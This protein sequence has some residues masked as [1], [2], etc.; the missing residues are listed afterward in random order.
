VIGSTSFLSIPIYTR[1]VS[2]APRTFLTD[3]YQFSCSPVEENYDS[4]LF[5]HLGSHTC[6]NCCQLLRFLKRDFVSVLK[7]L[8]LCRK[9]FAISHLAN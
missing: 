9:G 3:F 6:I 7:I 8:E 1:L 2:F 5:D 4:R